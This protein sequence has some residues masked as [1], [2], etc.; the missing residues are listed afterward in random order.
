VKKQLPSALKERLGGILGEEALCRMEAQSNAER[1]S[2]RVNTLKTDYEEAIGALEEKGFH[3]QRIPW[4][5]RGLWVENKPGLDDTIEYVLGHYYIQDAASMIPVTVLEPCEGDITLDM[6]A[7]PGSKTTQI[8][9]HMENKGALVANEYN[10]SRLGPLKFNLNKYGVVNT[11]VTTMDATERWDCTMKFSKILLDAPCSCEGQIHNPDAM[12]QWSMG[13]V[14]R[15]SHAQKRMIENAAGLLA[16]GGT[17]IYSTCTLAPEENEEVIDHIL[18]K[19][20]GI[21]VE[22]IRLDGISTHP[23][24]ASWRGRE[25][26]AEVK[27][28]LRINPLENNTEGFYIAKLSK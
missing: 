27:R 6:T 21:R 26:S 5:A 20:G 17:L 22:K 10:A 19:D 24:I 28:T 18:E 3:P 14:G 9:D 16:E 15:C 4:C 2:V 11:I 13:K 1:R 12:K 25:Y 23:G 8:A 7:A